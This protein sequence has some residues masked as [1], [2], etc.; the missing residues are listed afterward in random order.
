MNSP[1]FETW[2]LKNF[3]DT[4]IPLYTFFK[5]VMKTVGWNKEAA[6]TDSFGF[7]KEDLCIMKI[8]NTFF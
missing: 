7:L 1:G 8:L 4:W 5:P 3:V 6:A 2:A